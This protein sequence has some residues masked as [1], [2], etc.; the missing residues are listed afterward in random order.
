MATATSSAE[1]QHADSAAGRGMAVRANQ[2]L[3]RDSKTLQMELVAN[4]VSGARKIDT[5]FFGD[6]LYELM[7]VGIFKA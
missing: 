1:S 2:G 6:R 3:S 7:V 5:V 4:S